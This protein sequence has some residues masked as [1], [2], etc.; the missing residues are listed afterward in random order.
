MGNAVTWTHADTNR[1]GG[2]MQVAEF[3]VTAGADGTDT[4]TTAQELVGQ[5]V[6]WEL[7]SAA[8]SA[9]GTIYGYE[10]L[11][12]LAQGT[13]DYWMLYGTAG[14]AIEVVVYPLVNAAATTN[15]GGA[16]TTPG[17]EP[18]ALCGRQTV[19]LA[20]ITEGNTAVVRLYVRS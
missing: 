13:R 2:S 16:L 9:Q 14:G 10:Y 17:P 20:G 19:E 18:R 3:T 11:T 8:L 5:V 6:K 7:D 1:Y 15:V 4:A 12:D